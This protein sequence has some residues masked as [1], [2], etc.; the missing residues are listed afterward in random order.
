MLALAGIF[1]RL[2]KIHWAV[3]LCEVSDLAAQGQGPTG[4]VSANL[5]GDAG[6][7]GP[8]TTLRE[9]TFSN[10]ELKLIHCGLGVAVMK[11]KRGHPTT[12][13]TKQIV[14]SLTGSVL[15]ATPFI[16]YSASGDYNPASSLLSITA[17]IS[18]TGRLV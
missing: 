12:D 15:C 18:Y 7:V 4:Y 9:A 3:C 5:P 11:T 13:K 1:Q 6:A 17:E 8:W 2:V 10:T 16:N 14:Q